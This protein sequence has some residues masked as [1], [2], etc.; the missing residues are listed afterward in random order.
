MNQ[1]NSGHITPRVTG[2]KMNVDEVIN[3]F[4]GM[5]EDIT[6]G[7]NKLL[8]RNRGK[9]K[10]T[11]ETPLRTLPDLTVNL[12]HLNQS[13]Q[14]YRI[15][16]NQTWNNFIGHSMG[17]YLHNSPNQFTFRVNDM[18][19]EPIPWNYNGTLSTK[20]KQGDEIIVT[21]NDES[22]AFTLTIT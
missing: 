22:V 5:I 7:V 17:Q 3:D 16:F 9:K 1:T 15:D 18:W 8:N 21:F 6:K 14:C 13:A 2:V 4:S 10:K 19:H 11:K 12:T 20:V